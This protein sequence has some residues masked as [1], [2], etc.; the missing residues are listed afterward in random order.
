MFFFF[1]FTVGDIE[2]LVVERYILQYLVEMVAV[3][4]GDEYLS[5]VGTGDELHDLFHTVC[6]ELVENVVKQQHGCGVGGSAFEKVELC[7]L[8]RKNEG[9]VLTLA[10]FALH[11]IAVEQHF[12][13]VA[14]H[15]VKRIA[16]GTVAE[17]VALYYIE[18][19]ATLGMR[20]IA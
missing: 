19:V 8:Q 12:K 4:V 15:A 5:E 10:S 20:H 7:K 1:Y 14:M 17:T 6:V 3:G 9:L 16:Y 11:L 2:Q 18:Q 13:V